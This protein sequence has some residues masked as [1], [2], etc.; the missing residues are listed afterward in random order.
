MRPLDNFNF[1]KL[2]TYDKSI[3]EIQNQIHEL[4]IRVE[5]CGNVLYENDRVQLIKNIEWL[6]RFYE[7]AERNLLNGN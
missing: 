2:D 6:K 7:S 3:Q 1:S 4:I 5:E